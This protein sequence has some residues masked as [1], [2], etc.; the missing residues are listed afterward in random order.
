MSV[1]AS[2]EEEAIKKAALE[3]FGASTVAPG[4]M[5]SYKVQENAKQNASEHD[6][7]FAKEK[8]DHPEFTD[9]QIEEIVADHIRL[10]ENN[11]NSSGLTIK[12]KD[13]KFCIYDGSREV[14]VKDTRAAAESYIAEVKDAEDFK[15]EDAKKNYKRQV[16]LNSGDVNFQTEYDKRYVKWEQSAWVVRRLEKEG[17]RGTSEHSSAVRE[18]DLLEREMEAVMKKLPNSKRKVTLKNKVQGQV[19]LKKQ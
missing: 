5:A 2:S 13:G 3:M 12:E 11:K 19:I 7:M 16:T 1:E 15:A 17:K 6:A 9:A 18:R 14:A 4:M 10:G 8:A